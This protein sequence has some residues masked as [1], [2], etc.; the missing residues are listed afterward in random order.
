[1]SNRAAAWPLAAIVLLAAMACG[2]QR[3]AENAAGELS[4][5]VESSLPREHRAVPALIWLEALPGTASPPFAPHGHYT[6]VQKNRT[7]SPHLQVIPVGSVVEFPNKDPFFHNV[8]SLFGGKRFDLGLYEA[9]SSKS[10]TF[11]RKGVSYIFCNI[12]P[13]MS[14]IVITLDTPLYAIADAQDGFRLRR[15]P[16]GD[17]TLHLW[18]EGVPQSFLD[19]LSRP[20]HI[21]AHPVDLG[22]VR[23][24]IAAASGTPHDNLYGKPYSRESKSPY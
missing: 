22:I 18:A 23:A 13:E 17:Y 19:K 21:P 15:I 16:P 9:G 3:P 5:R 11:S 12:H 4:L 24:P 7:F 20:V 10:V 2:Q 14:A 6:L 1:M 8:F